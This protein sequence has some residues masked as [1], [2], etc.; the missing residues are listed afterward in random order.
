M[1]KKIIK[2]II[3]NSPPDIVWNAWTCPEHLTSFFAPEVDVEIKPG[4]KFEMYFL[5]D[6]PPGTRGG[7][8]NRILSFVPE[9]MLSFEWNAPPTYPNVRKEKTWVVLFFNPL[10]SHRTSLSLYHLG[11]K[12]GNEWEQVYEYFVKAWDIVL[13]NL[14][15]YLEK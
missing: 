2:Q 8:G 11:W 7:E 4:G 1:E 9:K 15:N 6:N 12:T 13:N 14:T 3:I 10:P 5:L